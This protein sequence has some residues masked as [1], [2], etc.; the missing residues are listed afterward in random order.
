MGA[1]ENAVQKACLDFLRLSKVFAWRSNNTAVYDST[2]GCYRSHAG[3]KG[4]PDICGL[5]PN[6]ALFVECK[7]ATGKI[8]PEQAA[9]HAQARALGAVVIVA[10]S[11]DDLRKGL[12][13]YCQEKP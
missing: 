2:R 11:V 5:L 4:L 3:I 6:A 10:R 13:E 12:M 7:S 8:S 1:A 9:F